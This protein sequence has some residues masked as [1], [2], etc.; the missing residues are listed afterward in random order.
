[1]KL[2][3]DVIFYIYKIYYSN[4]VISQIPKETKYFFHRMH[5]KN[6]V[7]PE[8]LEYSSGEHVSKLI[9][10][11]ISD[12][13]YDFHVIHFTNNDWDPYYFLLRDA[14]LQKNLDLFLFANFKDVLQHLRIE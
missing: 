12:Y 11:Y 6:S 5:Y 13:P 10:N 2:N 9:N 14:H 4:Y 8:L 3:E 7:L 1:M